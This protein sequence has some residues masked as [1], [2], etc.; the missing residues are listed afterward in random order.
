MIPWVTVIGAALQVAL[1]LIKSYY[2]TKADA[3]QLHTDKAKEIS[4]AIV[5]GDHGR[6][7]SVIDRLRS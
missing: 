1:L 6:I 2:E 5:S 7:H 4:D 3:K